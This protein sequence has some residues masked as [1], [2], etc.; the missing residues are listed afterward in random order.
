MIFNNKNITTDSVYF[1]NEEKNKLVSSFSDLFSMLDEEYSKTYEEN[2]VY[3]D[4]VTI[5]IKSSKDI[6][7]LVFHYP[8]REEDKDEVNYT[9]IK[10]LVD[11]IDDLYTGS[12]FEFIKDQEGLD[13]DYVAKIAYG[14]NDLFVFLNNIEL[15]LDEL[16]A[17]SPSAW[18]SMNKINLNLFYMIRSIIAK[19]KT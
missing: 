14:D 12:N 2:V 16:E 15:S 11:A 19:L 17:R 6:F 1:S 9:Q 4:E 7:S 3:F 13:Y 8:E 5:F 18:K 10:K